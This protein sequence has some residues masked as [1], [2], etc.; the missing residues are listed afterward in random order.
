MKKPAHKYIVLHQKRERQILDTAKA[1]I[2]ANSITTVTMSDIAAACD[3]SRQTLYK[4]FG[5]FDAVLY[6]IQE[7]IIGRLPALE[8]TDITTCLC[9]MADMLYH[10]YRTNPDDF[11]FI[12]MFDVY[13]HTNRTEEEINRHYRGIVRRR[14]PQLSQIMRQEVCLTGPYTAQEVF[15][16]ALH[17]IWAFITRIAVLGDYFEESG[18]VPE[19]RSLEILKDMIR[20]YLR[21]N[22]IEDA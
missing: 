10:Y 19:A 2:L 22:G 18:S 14:L 8:P 5:S 16:C 21:T 17:M 12:C 4:Y 13:I 20:S 3:I 6:G 7:D 1:L 15:A 11:M 9:G